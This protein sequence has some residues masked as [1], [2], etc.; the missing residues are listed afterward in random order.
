VP[1]SGGQ[2]VA[3]GFEEH[4]LDDVAAAMG[5]VE[6]VLE[7]NQWRSLVIRKSSGRDDLDRFRFQRDTVALDELVFVH[8][9]FGLLR[10][11]GHW[12]ELVGRELV[13][14]IGGILGDGDDAQIRGAKMALDRVV[15]VFHGER[16]ERGLD[17]GL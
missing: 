5:R 6:R 16:G 13:F 3:S 9:F 17:V 10:V 15:D 12:R 7:K 8:D 11:V 2:L 4:E 1:G 14:E